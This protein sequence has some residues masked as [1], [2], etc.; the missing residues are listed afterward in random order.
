MCLL[1]LSADVPLYTD[2]F[3][4]LIPTVIVKPPN[5]VLHVLPTLIIGEENFHNLIAIY[6]IVTLENVY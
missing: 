6:E 5:F 1:C 3:I 4:L 2:T